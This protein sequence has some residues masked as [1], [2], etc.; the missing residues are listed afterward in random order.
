LTATKKPRPNATAVLL[1]ILALIIGL[2]ALS[3]CW[4]PQVSEYILWVG[5]AGVA[6]GGI[7]LLIGFMQGRGIGLNVTAAILS[8]AAILV[9]M[10]LPGEEKKPSSHGE[11]T[12]TRPD[13]GRDTGT[14][15][16]TTEPEIKIDEWVTAPFGTARV[17]D[18]VIRVASARIDRAKGLDGKSFTPGQQ[19]L[20]QLEVSNTNPKTKG[21]YKGAALGHTGDGAPRL[22]DDNHVPY[23]VAD[24]GVG[25]PIQG[26]LGKTAVD[27]TVTDLLVFDLPTDKCKELLLEVPGTNFGGAGRVRFKI[28]RSIVSGKIEITPPPPD[29]TVEQLLKDMKN[30]NPLLRKDAIVKL[31]AHGA[32]AAPAVPDLSVILIKDPDFNVRIATAATLGQLGPTAKMVVPQL[33]QALRRD[34]VPKVR[35]QCAESLGQLGADAKSAVPDLIGAFTD[36]DE[37][38]ARKAFD[39]VKRIEPPK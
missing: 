28:P 31:G 24:F 18:M 11:T 7:G 33:V 12:D 37:E 14:D 39:A 9:P 38:V 30:A 22:T 2:V 27:K 25:K 21:D 4:I 34:L 13:T 26:Q 8:G 16:K 32:K 6:V 19:L 23:R 10:V 35:A 3:I 15:T 20:V 5:L 29:T 1:G 36:M 17:G